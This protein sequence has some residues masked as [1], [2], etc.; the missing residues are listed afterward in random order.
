MPGERLVRRLEPWRLVDL[1]VDDDGRARG[2]VAQNLRTLEFKSFAADGIVLATGGYGS[3]FEGAACNA[4]NLGAAL[5]IAYRHGA[6]LANLEFTG[7]CPTVLAAGPRRVALP[8]WLRW[9]GARLWVTTKDAKDTRE[10]S[11][12]DRRYPLETGSAF[13]TRSEP[14]AA[15]ATRAVVEVGAGPGGKARAFLDLTHLDAERLGVVSDSLG[16]VLRAAF[17]LDPARHPLPV[18]A[19]VQHT[20][21]GLWVDADSNYGHPSARQHASSLPGL[22]AA[23]EACHQYHGAH[24]LAGNLALG[25]IAGGISAARG[26]LGYRHALGKSAFDLP[27]SLFDRPCGDAEQAFEAMLGREG[28]QGFSPG[29]LLAE[30]QIAMAAGSGL[31]R[32]AEGLE[33]LLETLGSLEER[34]REVSARGPRNVFN[35]EAVLASELPQAVLLARAVVTAALS[36]EESRGTHKRLDRDQ[37]GAIPPRATLI[38]ARDGDPELI[39]DFEYRAGDQRVAIRSEVNHGE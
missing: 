13:E 17:G 3:L 14:D 37:G 36:R 35:P 4:S 6:V 34:A 15:R 25:D 31:E 19:A 29:A 18:R 23:G 9:L 39:D 7:P 5:A 11:E 20:L 12:K 16:G 21:G 22:Y 8:E 33:R 38:R 28:G 26:V 27:N 2:V 30:L 1:I 32:D 24:A 10:V